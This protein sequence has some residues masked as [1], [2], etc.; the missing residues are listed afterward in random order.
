MGKILV[1]PRLRGKLEIARTKWL[2]PCALKLVIDDLSHLPASLDD[3]MNTPSR[4]VE[5]L[6]ATPPHPYENC[7]MYVLHVRTG[8]FMRGELIDTIF[9]GTNE[10]IANGH[11]AGLRAIFYFRTQRNGDQEL[12]DI[13]IWDMGDH[14]VSVHN[15]ECRHGIYRHLKPRR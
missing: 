1:D 10:N 11:G 8:R 2:A 3:W 6:S 9:S 15:G 4:K 12:V 5:H 14:A 13:V 7:E